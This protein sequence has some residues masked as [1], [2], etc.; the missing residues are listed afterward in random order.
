M[1]S[2]DRDVVG[3]EE[4]I[5][6]LVGFLDSPTTLPGVFLLEGEAGIGKTTL[7][8]HGVDAA[9]ARGYRVLSCRTSGSEAQLSFVALG[10]LLGDVLDDVMP[11]LP[12][13]QAN[14]LAVALLVDEGEGP[15]P[16]RRAI[17]LA[18]TGALRALA[19]EGPMVVAIDDI[20]WLDPSSAFLLEFAL[21]RLEGDALA[22][23]LALR[24][25]EATPSAVDLDRAL[26][27]ERLRRLRVGP[28]SMGAMHRLLSE[29]LDLVLPRPRLR[30]LRELSGGN[31][32]FALELGRALRRGAIQLE[33]GE[34]LPG[35]L[36]ALVRDRL[37]TLPA[38]TRPALLAASA[39]SDPTLEL[40][41]RAVGG[42]ATDRL[43][44]AVAAQVIEF[45]GTGIRFTHPLL[46]SGVYA[47]AAGEDRRALHR[48]LAQ[49]LPDPEEHARHLALGTD[50]PDDGVAT[51]LERAA[52]L[53]HARGALAAAVELSEQARR[54][55]PVEMDESGHRRTI[56]AASYA[57]EAGESGRARELL[58]AARGRAQ[59][60]A[61]RGEILMLLGTIEEYEG[62]R[63][64]AVELYRDARRDAENDGGLR[65]RIEEGLASAL[66]LMRKDLP[67]AAEH[68]RAAVSLADEAGDV[69][70]TIAALSEVALVDAVSGGSEWRPALG[71]GRDLE[72]RAGPVPIAVSA[73]FTL[74]IL[75]SWT[76]ELAESRELLSSLRL[77]A[78]ERAEES[79]LPWTL[80]HLAWV[81]FLAGQWGEASR[82]AEEG[83]ETALQTGQE[84]QRA[85]ALAIRALVRACR[86]EVE[87]ARDDA[88]TTLA[89]ADERGVMV[90]SILAATALGVLELSLGNPEAV[91]RQLGPLVTRLEEGG[92]REPGSMRFVFDDIEALI[93]LGRLDEAEPLLDL[94]EGRAQRLDRASAVAAAARCRGLL[95]AARGD[96]DAA[97][98]SLEGAL[99]EHERVSMPFE[100]ARTLLALGVTRRRAR[101][102][103]P[104]RETLER[105]LAGFE[106]LGARLWADRTRAE[107]ARIGGRA[108][109][110]GELTETERRI[111]ALA[112]EGHSNK[113]IAAALFVTPKTVG[114]QLSRIYRKVGV[115]SRTEL[116]RRLSADAEAPK[117]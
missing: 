74:A 116:A 14:A 100:E 43:A 108:P 80:V 97:L 93:A 59:P 76:D 42:R 109:A 81:E 28:L 25:E 1:D 4:E 79:G 11:A 22:F 30:R 6:A 34:P 107:L 84:P 58:S 72:Q 56:Q 23:L 64:E 89:L 8:R 17:A 114:T 16:D 53:A 44:P 95:E 106:R 117:L 91:H 103:R 101:M 9:A 115:R 2:S 27:E 10:D 68:A 102:K 71:R 54:L 96:T 21:R 48:R 90:A 62:D 98:A 40:V 5:A 55:T 37:A 85:F 35:S 70:T 50:S 32:L 92:V 46:A 13:P 88:A 65:A 41:E 3:R 39:A 111:A 49:L 69:V 66:F 82:W 87:A 24:E 52:V 12:R 61:E 73:T 83:H 29:R 33:P 26:P 38:E 15:P 94:V 51:A 110:S 45:E 36:A 31:P 77:Y 104:A 7:W 20:Q 19:R 47:A 60:G 63:Q 113:E 57:W 18:F 112:V 78:E 67:A 105:A 75:F 99:A 86:G